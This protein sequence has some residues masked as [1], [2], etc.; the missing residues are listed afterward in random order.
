MK[1]TTLLIL[2]LISLKSIGQESKL[3]ITIDERIETLYSVAFFNDYFLINS[4][5][6]LY[7]NTLKNKLNVLK[8]HKAVQLFDSLSTKYNFSYYRTVEWILQYSNFPE[9]KKTKNKADDYSTVSEDKEY[10]LEE[11]K[12]ELIKFN[13]DTLFQKY[14]KAIKPLN[15][16]IISQVQN[17]KT[18]NKLPSYIE[19]YYGKKL[20]SY[21]LILSPLLHAGGFN[22]EIINANGE[23]EVYALLGPN[24][25][26]DFVPYF[27]KDFIETDLI[28]HE[29]GHSFV[30]PLMEKY[31]NN[32]ES[33]RS[34]YFTKELE[35]NGKDQGYSEWKYIF[36]ELL[37]RAT[38][39]H[40]AKQKFGNKKAEKLLDFEKSVGFE[41]VEKIVE[42]LK[43]YELNR[44]T[45]ATFDEFY[46][47]L[48]ER[49]KN[50]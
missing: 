49:M 50:H 25:E 24:G 11:F 29:F 39:I 7:K 42:I 6:N 17:S 12:D 22:S 1:N 16:K 21:N 48:I 46:P 41:L 8:N 36:N 28:L 10:L 43:E 3:K 47:I 27:D 19:D 14:L 35:K 9:L 32:V 44:H 34:T 40:I 38:T 18:I 13:Q 45:Y 15:E 30:N 20:N 37:L 2:L 23:K 4:H 31:E 26:I 5:E 33:L